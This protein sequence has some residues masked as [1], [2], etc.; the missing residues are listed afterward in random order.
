MSFLRH[1]EIYQVSESSP[2]DKLLIER[3]RPCGHALTHRLDES[4]VGYSLA[5]CSP[6]EP[7]SASPTGAYSVTM[8]W[9]IA[10]KHSLECGPHLNLLSHFRGAP[11]LPPTTSRAWRCIPTS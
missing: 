7:A 9:R 10:R 5:G 8:P 4:P 2:G 1:Q 6:A 3:A 11:Q